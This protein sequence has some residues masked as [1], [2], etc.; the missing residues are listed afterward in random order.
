MKQITIIVPDAHV[1]AVIGC[2]ADI[3]VELHVT[4]YGEPEEREKAVAP[5]M[6]RP[7]RGNPRLPSETRLGKI[8]LSLLPEVGSE[9]DVTKVEDAIE[10]EKF[11]RSSTSG[12]LSHLKKEGTL[13]R[14]DRDGVRLVRRLR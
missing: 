1:A 8:V 14:S 5:R 4:Q 6:P 2:V 7:P 9:V 11:A 13:E 3:A 10:H 12:I